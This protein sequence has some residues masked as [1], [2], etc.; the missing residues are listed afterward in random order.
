M[1]A[2]T[3]KKMRAQARAEGNDKKAIAAAEEA[4]KKKKTKIVTWV[5]V[6]AVVLF[7]AAVLFLN[8]SAMYRNTTALTVNGE[9]FSP[10]QVGYEYAKAYQN[11]S[12][13]YGEYASIFGLDTSYGIAGLANQT[14]PMA[15][16]EGQTWKD[17][18]VQSAEE[19]LKQT[20]ALNQYAQQN[21]ISL[22]DEEITAAE[23]NCNVIEEA[24]AAYGFANGDKFLAGNYGK[25]INVDL[26]KDMDLRSMLASKA[27]SAYADTVEV[28]DEEVAELYPSV[29]ARHILVKAEAD[30]NGE[31]SEEAIAAAKTKAEEILN[32]WKDGDAT[33]E[34]FA[35]LAEKYSEDEG[36][37]TNGGLYTNIMENQM[38]QE[39][40]DFCFAEDR[41]P[42]DTGIVEG[43]NGSYEGWHVVYFVGT[44]DPA[45]N[46]TGRNN[47]L[48]EKLSAWMENLTA[49]MQVTE[50]FWMRL[51]GKF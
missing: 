22:T 16:E 44:G 15:E 21:G 8:S 9:N 49:D 35:A 14:C 26:V 12:N 40:N 23:D 19:S 2:S 17:Y 33:E 20:V 7:V 6:A 37:N 51:V 48:S 11:F 13:T 24:A 41:K 10:A 30:E 5:V 43:N 18:F 3:E 38:V 4:A 36:S 31:Y 25:G 1:S 29:D 34:S 27:Y 42:G 32:E 39:F 50:N 28:T 46:E 45:A 47:V